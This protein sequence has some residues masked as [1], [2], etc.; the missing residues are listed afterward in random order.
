MLIFHYDFFS[1][2]LAS[3]LTALELAVDGLLFALTPLVAS[4]LNALDALVFTA[5]ITVLGI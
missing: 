5:L 1:A 4:L 3:I 2:T